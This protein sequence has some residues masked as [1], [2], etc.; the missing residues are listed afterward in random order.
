MKIKTKGIQIHHNSTEIGKKE[1]LIYQSL[2]MTT[3]TASGI[4][5]SKRNYVGT[6]L[7]NLCLRL[8]NISL[9][10]TESQKSLFHSLQELL[11]LVILVQL[12][13]HSA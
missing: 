6:T 11:V 1:Q 7:T 9:T 4:P 12:V 8:G 3:M 13:H 5:L 2:T 10:D